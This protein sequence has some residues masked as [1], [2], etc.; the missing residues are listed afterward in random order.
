MNCKTRLVSALKGIS[1]EVATFSRNADRLSISLRMS[2]SLHAQLVKQAAR[3]RVSL[4]LWLNTVLAEFVG[5][6]VVAVPASMGPGPGDEL[7]ISETAA[8]AA[9][10]FREGMIGIAEKFLASWPRQRLACRARRSR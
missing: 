4:N 8:A 3:N 6:L 5:S 1:T 2:S 7:T 10:L 9:C